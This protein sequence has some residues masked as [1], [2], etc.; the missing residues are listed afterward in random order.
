MVEFCSLTYGIFLCE[1]CAKRHKDL[2][3]HSDSLKKLHDNDW[4]EEQMK[5]FMAGNGGNW[6]F[7]DFMSKHSLN[8]KP[9]YEKYGSEE[10]KY[11]A[12]LLKS[13]VTG[14]ELAVVMNCSNF[15]ENKEKIK[16]IIKRKEKAEGEYSKDQ[17]RD[18]SSLDE[19]MIIDNH[20]KGKKGM[21]HHI[22]G[23]EQKDDIDK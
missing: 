22:K 21:T 16:E 14:N 10:A 20:M 18:K 9:I 12:N 8:D 15:E 5:Y 2:L 23:S 17:Q 13:K 7:I 6:E 3:P 4:T 11:Y 1:A 19:H